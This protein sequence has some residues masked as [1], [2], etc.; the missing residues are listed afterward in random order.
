M[1]TEPTTPTPM[2]APAP[3]PR[4]ARMGWLAQML[5]GGGAQ[6]QIAVYHH[7]TLFF[8]WPV[9][10]LGF[11]FALITYYHGSVLAIVPEGTEAAESRTVD[12]TGQGEHEPRQVLI[13]PKGEPFI[14]HKD[15]EGNI[16]AHPKIHMARHR[17]LGTIYTIVLLLVI[18][19]TNISVRGLWSLFVLLLVLMLTIIFALAGWWSVIFRGLGQLSVYINMGGYLLISSV[20]FVLWLVNVLF[21]DRQTYMIFTPGQVRVRLVIGGE[22]TVYDTTGM[23]VQ[24]QRNDMF[25]HWLLG[26]G[27]GDLVIR[28]V[29]LAYAL[30]LD[31]VLNVSRVARRIEEMIKEKVVV[32][33]AGE[34]H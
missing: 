14:K 31:N 30:E 26:F 23:V 19:M 17:T 28:P 20:L 18:A 34:A 32:R 27:S 6:D 10:L 2:P 13:L 11:V 1:S 21:F 22:E 29:G 24:R 4:R 9:W 25:R 12:T 15:A 7:A 3:P 33:G 8:W 16:T 5:G